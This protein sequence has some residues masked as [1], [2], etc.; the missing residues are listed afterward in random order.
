VSRIIEQPRYVCPLGAQQT[1][2]G[3]K[4][5]IPIVHAG[6]GCS[7]KIFEALCYN[8]GFQGEG[9]A[10]GSAIPA[11]NSSEKDIVFGGEEKLRSTI[12]GTLKVMAGDLFVV[13]TGCTAEIVGDDVAQVAAEYRRKGIPIVNAETGGFKG[14]NY[15]GH[16]LVIQAII[17]QFIG[18]VRPEVKKGLV[19]VFSV[20]PFQDTY[21]R[22]DLEEIKHL[23][24]KIGLE[25]NILFGYGSKGIEEWRNI[26]HAEFNLVLSPWVGLDTAKLLENKYGTPYLHYP[27]L[28]M[29]AV[30]TSKFLETVGAF[31]A[32]DK[33]KIDEVIQK[34]EERFY[35]YLQGA[36]D[37][38]TESRNTLPHQFYTIADSTY[39]LGVSR[40][41]VNELGMVPGVQYVIDDPADSYID[42]IQKE[43]HQISADFDTKV[44]LENDGGKIHELIRKKGHRAKETLI[45]GSSWEKDLARDVKGFLIYLSVPITYQL[46]LNKTYVGYQGGL[47]LTEDVYSQVLEG[48]A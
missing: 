40:F 32:I 36:T 13:L 47:N 12:E 4:R 20:L 6:P 43:F 26:P 11:T 28:P 23:L 1:V 9:Y 22:A 38:L 31:G 2:L 3:I 39:A 7:S 15:K 33:K 8:S 18:E 34:E 29:G 35:E 14:N 19:N 10:G 5:A 48:N 21:W 24:E 27:V 46:V 25:A 16:E 41:L 44:V 42:L 30:E 17:N 37:F 45:L